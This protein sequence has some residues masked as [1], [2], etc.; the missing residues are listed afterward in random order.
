MRPLCTAGGLARNGEP[1]GASSA[2]AQPDRELVTCGFAVHRDARI[3]TAESH[4]LRPQMNGG[5]GGERP[6][7]PLHKASN[8]SARSVWALLRKSVMDGRESHGR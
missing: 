8:C 2:H 1:Q 6:V 3:A 5:A 4:A 7:R